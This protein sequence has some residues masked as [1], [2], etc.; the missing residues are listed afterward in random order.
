MKADSDTDPARTAFR[1]L[2]VVGV[3]LATGALSL[4]VQGRLPG[5]WAQIGN[6]GAVWLAVSF[7]MGALWRSPR[8]ALGAGLAALAGCLIGYFAT[9]MASGV[10][11]AAYFVALWSVV[12]LVG[13]PLFG[14]AGYGWRVPHRVS[15]VAGLG[16]LGG[17]FVSEGLFTLLVNQHFT[18][19]WP[20]VVV[21]LIMPL[22]LGRSW[23]D[24]L[25]ASAASLGAAMLGAGAYAVINW[26]ATSGAL[27]WGDP[28]ASAPRRVLS[29]VL[30]LT[31]DSGCTMDP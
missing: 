19:G 15:H 16:L 17:L 29:R 20:L 5:D 6:S 23:R 22:M 31:R 11:Y 2:I 3:G 8:Q 30:E 1:C 12:A 26:L 9:G 27:S 7:S 14:L 28:S 4:L 24:R 25:W 10:P 13:G 18:T 21:G